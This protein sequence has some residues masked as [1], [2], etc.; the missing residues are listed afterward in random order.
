MKKLA[1]VLICF[2]FSF[3]LSAKRVSILS[4]IDNPM[5]LKVD[6]KYIY[7]INDNKIFIYSRYDFKLLKKL[8]KAGEGPGEFK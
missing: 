2:F 6:D 4:D 1:M 8:G 7:I 3:A 5:N